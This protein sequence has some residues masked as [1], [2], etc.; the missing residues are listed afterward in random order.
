MYMRLLKKILEYFPISKL[1]FR[2]QVS[3]DEL[4]L[5]VKAFLLETNST[6]VRWQAHALLLAIYK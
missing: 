1:K 2:L 4:K 6:S 5:F 3:Q